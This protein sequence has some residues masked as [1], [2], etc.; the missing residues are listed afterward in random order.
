MVSVM[1]VLCV[2][3]IVCACVNVLCV[4]WGMEMCFAYAVGYVL[5]CV[6]PIVC[7]VRVVCHMYC[8]AVCTCMH[9]WG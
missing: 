9:W 6:L 1:H 5:V 8:V 3:C 7:V 4:A 2:V